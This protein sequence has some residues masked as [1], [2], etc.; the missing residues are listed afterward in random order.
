MEPGQTQG[1]CLHT[2]ATREFPHG[3]LRHRADYDVE[4]IKKMQREARI[5][6]SWL[7]EKVG[8]PDKDTRFVSSVFLI[9]YDSLWFGAVADY[10]SRPHSKANR[11][12][13]RGF[14]APEVLLKCNEQTGG[15]MLVF[16][17]DSLM[18][19]CFYNSTSDRC[20][21]SGDD[22]FILPRW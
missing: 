14:R 16:F 19:I 4:Q 6:S 20:M 21:V 5:K 3:R 12:G 15:K 9:N 13:T 17:C 1:A 7:S 8:Y 10:S 2:P 22:T 11:A 18:V